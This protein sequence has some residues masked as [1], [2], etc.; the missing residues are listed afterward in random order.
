MNM[1]SPPLI[2]YRIS[3]FFDKN[4]MGFI[5]KI[6][7]WLNRFLFAVWIPGSAKI[8]KNTILGY[9]GLGVV[10]HSRAIVG[11]NCVISQNVTIGRNLKDKDVPKIGDNVYIGPGTV[12]FGEIIIG[13]NVIIGANSVVNK[14][15][16]DNVVIAGC[17]ARII[18][19]NDIKQ[20]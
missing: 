19:I 9:W 12:I 17:P 20:I 6:I 14:S 1:I 2:L 7:S 8:G 3:H 16:P 10:I 5:F 13:N 15:F 18:K 4:R 11:N